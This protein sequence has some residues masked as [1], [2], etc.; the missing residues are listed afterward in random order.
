MKK[1]IL[2]LLSAAAMTVTALAVPFTA[3]ANEIENVVFQSGEET[4]WL[5]RENNTG[6]GKVIINDTEYT[7]ASTTA[8]ETS[9]FPGQAF[10]LEMPDTATLAYN[11]IQVRYGTSGSGQALEAGTY[12]L[13]VDYTAK[14]DK[15]A[16]KADGT[17]DESGNILYGR[18]NDNEFSSI[19]TGNVKLGETVSG[20]MTKEITLDKND[21]IEIQLYL[22][23][24]HGTVT[25]SNIR[26]TTPFTSDDESPEGA[27]ASFTKNGE[28]R[29]FTDLAEAV[30]AAGNNSTIEVL[31]DTT[32]SERVLL[33]NGNNGFGGI[34]NL[35]ING[36]GHT[37]SAP[38]GQN[39]AFEVPSSG[40][41]VLTINN[42]T[43]GSGSAQAIN[44]RSGGTLNLNNVTVNSTALKVES[45]TVN[46]KGSTI[47]SVLFNSPT[48][49]TK[50]D[51]DST[52]YIDGT[53]K[54]DGTA[55]TEALTL[56]TGTPANC[57]ATVEGDY[58]NNNGVISPKPTTP[59]GT[60]TMNATYIGSYEGDEDGST[61]AAYTA[62]FTTDS[63]EQMSFNTKEVTWSLGGASLKLSESSS[64]EGTQISVTKGFDVTY[65]IIISNVLYNSGDSAETLSV[66]FN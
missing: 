66:S 64:E 15:V 31:D 8:V 29:Y 39:M 27:V 51:L 45:A 21:N 49:S 46:A 48:S 13:K 12:T 59:T 5:L 41:C 36:N 35:T 20:T 42:A 57:R 2:A 10:T 7:A 40:S 63:D 6:G 62:K 32:L 26:V 44:V 18:F 50:I 23:R 47:N 25:Y 60:I 52:S 9:M 19:S 17:T 61:A 65:G 33:N 38:A 14:I 22:R 53:I 4:Q 11:P 1:K 56:I 58:E 55:P 43:I 28:T 3:S 37:I 16:K 30:K 54:I 34:T 24:A